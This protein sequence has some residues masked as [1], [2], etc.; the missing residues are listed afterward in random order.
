MRIPR[1]VQIEVGGSNEEVRRSFHALGLTFVLAL[2]LVYMILA[3]EFESLL[4]P[5]T[6]LL[7]VPLGLVGAILGLWLTGAGLTAVSL[8]GIIVLVGI[9]DN[10]AVVK[11]A[12]IN[13]ARAAGRTV[14]DAIREA[15]HARFRPIVINSVTAIL[16][17]LPMALGIGPGAQLQAP[18]A[19]AVLGG[20]VTGTAL[21][22]IVIPVVYSLVEDLRASHRG[23]R[24]GSLD[25]PGLPA[26][27][28]DA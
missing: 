11:V 1:E 4:H 21:T 24:N 13:Q 3:A 23:A 6:V 5:V 18:L 27:V 26:T 10:D 19:V 14:H 7:S 28:L 8:I 15:G 12:Y 22:L 9:V 17:L 16:G 25:S 20:L 2:L